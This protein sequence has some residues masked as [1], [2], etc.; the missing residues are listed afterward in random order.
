MHE[1]KVQ[2]QISKFCTFFS[3]D[4]CINLS[5]KKYQ[6]TGL[7]WLITVIQHQ[8]TGKRMDQPH[9]KFWKFNLIC[10]FSTAIQ[11]IATTS[12]RFLIEQ[13]TNLNLVLPYGEQE[14]LYNYLLKIFNHFEIEYKNTRFRGCLLDTSNYLHC[15]LQDWYF[16]RVI[17]NA[18]R[19]SECKLHAGGLH[20]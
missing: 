13:I 1:W 3:H 2:I 17:G 15:N 7:P 12:Q 11:I 10:C 5:W 20:Q 9:N 16:N 14:V 8:H 4:F 6:I 18:D 19:A